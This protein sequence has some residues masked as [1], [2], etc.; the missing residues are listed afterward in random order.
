MVPS[1]L[2][3]PVT[4]TTS[5]EGAP[6]AQRHAHVAAYRNLV[7]MQFQNIL[8]RIKMYLSH[9]LGERHGDH[10]PHFSW[11]KSHL[12]GAFNS[13]ACITHAQ[14]I[15]NIYV[16]IYMCVCVYLCVC[17]YT[18]PH[19]CRNIRLTR[20]HQTQFQQ[21]RVPPLGFK[22]ITTKKLKATTP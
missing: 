15:T 1:R 6:L 20:I 16:H 5:F 19:T 4:K 2:E 21:K 7:T 14:T 18:Y 12:V 9:L 8:S 3:S 11:I 13:Q 22:T 10:T 17:I